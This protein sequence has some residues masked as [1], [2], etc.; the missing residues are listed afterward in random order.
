MSTNDL[1][2]VDKSTI[3]NA[4]NGLFAKVFIEKGTTIAQFQGI[5]KSKAKYCSSDRSIIYFDNGHVL[6]CPTNDIASFANDAVDFP[7]EK[8]YLLEALEL[9]TPFYRKRDNLEIN[10]QIITYTDDYCAFLVATNDI[11]QN[12][13]IF[14]HYGFFHWFKQEM[15][16]GFL[17]RNDEIE[18]PVKLYNYIGFLSYIFEF[19]PETREIKINDSKDPE[20]ITII[21]CNNHYITMPLMKKPKSLEGILNMSQSI[22]IEE[23][24]KPS[25]FSTTINKITNFFK[26]F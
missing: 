23:K 16:R 9:D 4:G 12:E 11:K 13:E 2:Y 6:E 1:V 20:E 24:E 10:A 8:R 14:C 3:P 25:D 22:L 7:I 5:I 18:I 26:S 19:Y 15:K 17:F 21:T